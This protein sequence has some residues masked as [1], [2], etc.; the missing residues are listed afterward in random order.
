LLSNFYFSDRLA[1]K[2]HGERWEHR[3]DVASDQATARRTPHGQRA[4]APILL[5][6]RCADR[7][8]ADIVGLRVN[9]TGVQA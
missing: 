2:V 5:G 1:A 7:Q 3:W 8:G 9:D 6:H 4:S